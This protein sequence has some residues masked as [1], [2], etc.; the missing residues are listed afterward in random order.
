MHLSTFDYRNA[1]AIIPKTIVGELRNVLEAAVPGSEL[2]SRRFR[3]KLSKA[4]TGL[5][6]SDSIRVNPGSKIS[7]TSV[8]DGIGLCVQ[9]GN[10]SRFYADLLKLETLYK[11]RAVRAAIYLLP[12]KKWATAMGSNLANF[13]RF[14]EELGIFSESISVPILV[15]GFSGDK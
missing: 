12:Q 13:E 14:V 1:N 15:V 11:K 4:L 10:V 3:H 5:G 7:I 9:T 8:R 6:W 2:S